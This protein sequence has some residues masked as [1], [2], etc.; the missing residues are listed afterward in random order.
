M[1]WSF[2][3]VNGVFMLSD[4]HA[5]DIKMRT[6]AQT[7]IIEIRGDFFVFII[8]KVGL[9]WLILSGKTIR[10]VRLNGSDTQVRMLKEM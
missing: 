6:I 10:V 9:N 4:E 8:E 5:T 3:S 7:A 1:S 2:F